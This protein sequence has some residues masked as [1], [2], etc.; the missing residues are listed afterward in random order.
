MAGEFGEAH[1]ALIEPDGKTCAVKLWRCDPAAYLKK[2]FV[3]VR[4]SILFSATL[5]PLA[6]YMAALGLSEEDGDAALMLPSPFPSDHLLVLQ[7][8]LNTRYRQR[9][10]SAGQVARTIAAM[11]AARVGNYLACFPSY[12][13]LKLVLER[14]RE[15][16][17]ARALVQAPG[18]DERARAQ[19]IEAFTQPSDQS[20][21]A[22][23]AMGGLFAEGIDLPGE[24]LL[25]AAIVG[26]GMPQPSLEREVMAELLD[27]GEGGGRRAAYTVPG[28]E[29]VLQAAGRVI[30]TETDRG[31]VLL[32]DDRFAQ[33]EYKSLLPVNWRVRVAPD[34]DIARRAM[35][36]FWRE[37]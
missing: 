18:M 2:C 6:H 14:F 16:G 32:L 31:V 7:L 28:M 29:R 15:L 35:A 36:K 24:L 22:F 8:P 19:F 3:R 11:C 23:V 33:E 12:A 26:V 13:Y 5:S 9:E 1:R 34:I 30:R 20:R 10:E 4:G 21:V 17:A 25:G 27:D 37:G